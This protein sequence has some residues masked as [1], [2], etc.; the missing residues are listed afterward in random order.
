MVCV[1][2]LFNQISSV[3]IWLRVSHILVLLQA[4]TIGEMKSFEAERSLIEERSTSDALRLSSNFDSAQNEEGTPTVTKVTP[5]VLDFKKE[6]YPYPTPKTITVQVTQGEHEKTL[7]HGRSIHKSENTACSPASMQRGEENEDQMQTEEDKM[8]HDKTGGSSSEMSLIF[9]NS[10]PTNNAKGML[11]GDEERT[12]ENGIALKQPSPE[13]TSDSSDE[14][15]NEMV[16]QSENADEVFLNSGSNKITG[17]RLRRQRKTLEKEQPTRSSLRTRKKVIITKPD[18]ENIEKKGPCKKHFCLYCKTAFAQ[19]EKHLE[20]KHAEETD[21][22]HAIHFPKGSKVRQSML[23]QIR[24]KGDYEHNCHVVRSGERETVAKKQVKNP[25][26]SVRDFLPCQHCFA[27]YRKTDL[28]RHEQSCKVRKADQKSPERTEKSGIHKTMPQLHPMSEFLTKGC[29]EIIHIMHQDDISKHIRNDPLI[30]RFGNALSAKYEHDKSQFAYIA[31]K[32]RELGRFVLAVGELDSSVKYLHEVCVPSRF[33][34]AVEGA[35]KVSGFDPSSSKFKTVSL[36]SKIG[37]SLKRAAEIAFGE[38]RM[39]EDSETESEIKTF[40]HLLDTKWSQCFS[41]KALA[42]S[43]KQEVKKVEIDKSAVTEDL[44]KLHRFITEEEDEARRDLKERP[45]LSTWKK[46]SEATLAD[47]C[48]F[49][50]GRVGNIGRMLLQTYVH[51]KRKGA[52]LPSAD[53]IR[54]STKLELHLGT[55]FTRLELEGQF[56]RNMLVLL[57]ER[58]VLSV[59]LLIENR[60]QAGVSNTNP[61]LFARTEGPSFIRG[62][63]CFRRAAIECGV[64]NPEALLSASLREQ[65]ACCW[66]LMSLSE[67]ELDQVA[68][69]VGRSSQDCYRLSHNPSQLEDVSK[70]LVKMDRTLPTSPPST[71][72]DGD[73]FCSLGPFAFKLSFISKV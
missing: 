53:Q 63:D 25:S 16:D 38:S 64:K 72:R 57:T 1:L 51:K 30:C 21:V 50:R 23:D 6:K 71:A 26:V 52:F 17:T 54:K 33:E 22:A 9:D 61:Y 45:S 56:G 62:L 20:K 69:L 65:I 5:Q 68:K 7:K 15:E 40:I 14:A 3:L 12:E 35:K 32:M 41:R 4:C 28:W 58:M 31:Q 43:I 48:L 55:N 19:L 49:N 10:D 47:V 60:Q 18:T 2:S 29:E 46:L 36:V 73:Y 37:Y 66:Q 24:A 67:H 11:A 13:E 70:H 27:F 39:T 44:I 34:L 42:L 8:S 59:D